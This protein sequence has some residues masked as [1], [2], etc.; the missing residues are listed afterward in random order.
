MPEANAT[1]TKYILETTILGL[2]EKFENKYVSG[3]KDN[4]V[5][6]ARSLGWWV[7]CRGI[8]D[9]IFLDDEKP[10]LGVGDKIVLTLEKK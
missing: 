5:F 9:W 4:A 10:E 7:T 8:P 6:D 3:A 2:E 1:R